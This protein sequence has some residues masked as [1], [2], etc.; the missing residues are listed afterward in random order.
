MHDVAATEEC[1]REG[2]GVGEV[3]LDCCKLLIGPR[4]ARLWFDKL[5]MTRM[6]TM[7]RRLTM[8]RT[9]QGPDMITGA[10]EFAK[11]VRSDEA[12]SAG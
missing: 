7:T 2:A 6:L 10:Q 4:Q 12:C 8:T 9:R 11:H 3:A 5:T 1:A